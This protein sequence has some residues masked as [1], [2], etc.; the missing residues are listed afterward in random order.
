MHLSGHDTSCNTIS[1]YSSNHQT[2]SEHN[3]A[4]P[5]VEL[6]T[7]IRDNHVMPC[8]SQS[9]SVPWSAS[10]F[11][12][13]TLRSFTNTREAAKRYNKRNKDPGPH[14]VFVTGPEYKTITEYFSRLSLQSESRSSSPSSQSQSGRRLPT[15]GR[16]RQPSPTPAPVPR[17]KREVYQAAHGH[18]ADEAEMPPATSTHTTE[19]L[20]VE[21]M[22]LH[23]LPATPPKGK[24]GKAKGRAKGNNGVGK[25]SRHPQAG[26]EEEELSPQRESCKRKVISIL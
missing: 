2:A 8:W 3:L 25:G 19:A 6:Y 4:Q 21:D 16:S 22:D 26:E 24:G 7:R 13:D 14:Q 15:G 10:K 12:D 11:H 17:S 9:C 23:V 18:S 1:L 20:P 5:L